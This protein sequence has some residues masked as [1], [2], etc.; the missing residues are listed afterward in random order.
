MQGWD[1][2]KIYSL[3]CEKA[4]PPQILYQQ[5]GP[6]QGLAYAAGFHENVIF[7]GLAQ[8]QVLTF[9]KVYI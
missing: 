8:F 2:N 3:M 4:R 6:Y 1:Q 7:Y 9:N 5:L